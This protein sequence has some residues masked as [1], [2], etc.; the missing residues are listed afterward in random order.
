[1]PFGVRR[2]HGGLGNKP[3]EFTKL[4]GDNIRGKN[5]EVVRSNPV[6][7]AIMEFME[8]RDSWTGLATPLL[9]ELVGVAEKLK[10]DIR[11]KS[12]PK[13]P[14]TLT[15]RI[16]ELLSSLRDV[17][18]GVRFDYPAKRQIEICK[19]AS[20]APEASNT[21]DSRGLND[22]ATAGAP[23]QY[24]QSS[25]GNNVVER[26]GVGAIGATDASFPTTDGADN[27]PRDAE[28]EEA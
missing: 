27:D 28:W 15:R 26:Q 24:R 8:A 3:Y 19:V 2:S 25:V 21:N 18:V 11:D 10:L 4:Y 14:H 7:A 5:E 9:T 6:A 17:G 16:R 13:A 1:L 23:P 20:K 22:D 12:W